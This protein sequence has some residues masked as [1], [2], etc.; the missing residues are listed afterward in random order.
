MA[1]QPIKCERKKSSP[2]MISKLEI[3]ELQNSLSKLQKHVDRLE[4]RQD[5][6]TELV[7]RLAR[8]ECIA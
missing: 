2:D 5:S 8:G 6:T 1:V 3:L 7:E 4:R